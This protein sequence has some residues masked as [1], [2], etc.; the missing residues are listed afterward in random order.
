MTREELEKL[1]KNADKYSSATVRSTTQGGG[2]NQAQF[3]SLKENA[4]K[5]VSST[6]RYATQSELANYYKNGAPTLTDGIMKA[7]YGH[8]LKSQAY[9]SLSND[10][11]KMI[12]LNNQ[13]NAYKKAKDVFDKISY[14]ER[15]STSKKSD[16]WQKSKNL[17]DNL[18]N[19][20]RT[21]YQSIYGVDADFDKWLGSAVLQGV[22]QFNVGLANTGAMAGNLIP[23]AI[24][25]A[26]RYLKFGTDVGSTAQLR[27]A[28][29]LNDVKGST[30]YG[31]MMGGWVNQYEKAIGKPDEEM[32]G[33]LNS[34]EKLKHRASELSA[35]GNYNEA[36]I[37][38]NRAQEFYDRISK[39]YENYLK[40]NGTYWSIAEGD[41]LL[42]EYAQMVNDVY[43]REQENYEKQLEFQ[44]MTASGSGKGYEIAGQL[45]TSAVAALPYAGLSL[46]TGGASL[47]QFVPEGHTLVNAATLSGSGIGAQL[48]PQTTDII[49]KVSNILTSFGKDPQ[50]W[51]SFAQEAGNTY[52]EAIDA[53]ADA[54]VATLTATLVGLINGAIELGFGG[55]NAGIQDLPEKLLKGKGAGTR[56]AIQEWI[57][58]AIS[59]G[60]EEILQGVISNLAEKIAYNKDMK[61]IGEGGVIDPQALAQEG[62]MGGAVGALLGGGQ[63]MGVNIM[64]ESMQNRIDQAN[65]RLGQRYSEQADTIV[66]NARQ[67]GPET[68]SYQLASDILEKGSHTDAE[69]GELYRAYMGDTGYNQNL[70]T[71][72]IQAVQQRL[73][74]LGETSNT[75]ELAEIIAKEADGQK[76]TEAETQAIENSKYGQ[77]VVNELFNAY[78]GD[79]S[80]NWVRGLVTQDEMAAAKAAPELTQ[81][82]RAERI[83]SIEQ[84]RPER[85]E[86]D[87][88]DIDKLA[89]KYGEQANVFKEA[90]KSVEGTDLY[91]FDDAYHLVY[92]EAKAGLSEDTIRRDVKAS[93]LSP[94]A[95]KLAYNAGQS[96]IKMPKGSR[97]TGSA[98]VRLNGIDYKSLNNKQRASVRALQTIAQITG[99]RIE[100][101]DST[102][103]DGTLGEKQGWYSKG[104]IGIDINAGMLDKGDILNVAMLRTTSHELTH[105]IQDN[106]DTAY[107][108]LKDFVFS[109][110]QTYQFSDGKYRDA[111]TWI[112]SKMSQNKWEYEEGTAEFNKYYQQASDECVADACE[113]MLRDSTA[114]ETLA[115][116]N[117]SLAQRMLD[118]LK[119]LIADIKKAFSG[120]VETSLEARAML[121]SLD[122]L[123]KKWDAAL[124]G[125]VQNTKEY[126][127]DGVTMTNEEAFMDS[128]EAVQNQIRPPYTDKT[129]AFYEFADNLNSEARETFDLFYGFYQRSRLT[130]T[131]NAQ[132]KP[133]KGINISAP[134]L[135]VQQWNDK[136]KADKKWAECARGLAEF[137]PEKVRTAMRMN[138]DG[139]LK[140]NPLE[141]RFKMQISLAQRLVDALPLEKIDINYKL[142]NKTIKLS[143]GKA[144]QS[145][146][147][148][149]YRRAVI[150]E[151]RKLYAEGKLKKVSIGAMS[152]DRWGSLGFLA[153]NGKTG[154]SGDLTT[155]CPQMMFNEGCFYCYRRAA[156]ETG[157]NNKLVAQRV[158]YTGEILRIKDSDVKALNENGG[159]RIQSFGDWMPQFSAQLADILYDAELRGLQVKIITKEPSMIEYIARLENQGIGKSLYFNLSSDYAIEKGPAAPVNQGAES[160]A[161]V[162]WERPFMRTEDGTFWWKRAMTVEEAQK[163]R[164]KYPWVN[165][166][167][168]ATDIAEFIRG[169]RDP[170]VDVVTGYHGH[171]RTW[172]RIDSTTGEHKVQVEP[173]GDAGMPRF[174]F[175]PETKSWGIEYAGKTKVH[176]ALAQ[177]I[178]DNGLQMEYYTKTCCITGRCATCNGKCGALAR[179]FSVKNATNRDAESVAYWQD[180]MTKAEMDLD[181]DIDDVQNSLRVTPEQN[182]R[183][184]E[185]AKDPKK[186]EAELRKMVEQAARSA[187]YDVKAYHGTH[188]FG[189]TKFNRQGWSTYLTSK[190]SVAESFSGGIG[191]RGITQRLDGSM[192]EKELI[193]YA[194]NS[195]F[196]ENLQLAT[197]EQIDRAYERFNDY[198]KQGID[199]ARKNG[200]NI[201]YWEDDNLNSGIASLSEIRKLVAEKINQ[202]ANGGIYAMYAR[203]GKALTVNGNGNWYYEIPVTGDISKEIGSNK[204]STD[205]ILRYADEHGYDSVVYKN[206]RESGDSGN[207]GI[208]TVYAVVNP[209]VN[210]KSA[211][212]VTYDDS[213]N[214]IPLSER[215]NEEDE[216]IRYSRRPAQVKRD[217]GEKL[218]ESE[219]Y[220]LYSAHKLNLRGGQNLDEQIENI[221]T[222]GF[223]NTGGFTGNLMPTNL[224]YTQDENGNTKPANVSV[225]RYA[226][227]EGD[228]ILLVPK[229]GVNTKSD[230]VALG[231]KPSFDYEIV[232]ADYDYQPYYEMYSKAYDADVQYSQ[233]WT[234]NDGLLQLD[235][236]QA[237]WGININTDERDFISEILNSN[238]DV[239][240]TIETRANRNV[241]K[242]LLGQRVGL[243]ETHTGRPARLV[244]YATIS[245]IDRYDTREEF[246]A[247]ADKHR[248]TGGTYDYQE[249]VKKYGYTLTNVERVEPKEILSK[250]ISKR[251]LN[252]DTQYQLRE[253]IST[254]EAL[255][256]ALM[257]ITE[258][259]DERTRLVKYID[260][261]EKVDTAQA[262]VNELGKQ[263]HDI[264]FTKG[265]DRSN[266]A[267]LRAEK[268]KLE[269]DIERYDKMLIGL[270]STKPLKD[271]RDRALARANAELRN[272]QREDERAKKELVKNYTVAF[273]SLARSDAR[274]LA[275][276]A[277]ELAR[278]TSRVESFKRAANRRETT[279]IKNTIKKTVDEWRTQLEDK[280]KG[281]HIPRQLVIAVADMV[282]VL[283]TT[284]NTVSGL[285]K[286]TELQAL[287]SQLKND[288]D[289]K[290]AYDTSVAGMFDSLVEVIDETPLSEM[291]Y[292]QLSKVYDIVKA[293]K[294]TIAEARQ[295]KSKEYK[296]NIFDT[297]KAIINEMIEASPSFKSK[298]LEAIHIWQLDPESFFVGELAGFKKDA[299][300][301]Q[302]ARSFTEGTKRATMVEMAHQNHF[303][304]FITSRDIRRLTNW[305]KTIDVGLVDMKTG[306]KVMMPR[307]AALGMYMHTL[308]EDNQLAL[309]YG[310]LHVPGNWKTYYTG[311]AAESY[312]GEPIRV[313][314]EGNAEAINNI[315]E[316][317]KKIDEL[318]D[319]DDL[320]REEK[321]KLKEKYQNQQ[322]EYEQ[323][324]LGEIQAVRDRIYSQMTETEKKYVEAIQQWF[325]GPAKNFAN[326]VT[327]ELWDVK[328]AQVKNYWPM[329]RDKAFIQSGDIGASV[330]DVNLS[331]AGWLKQR[332]RSS[333]PIYLTDITYEL[334]Q[335]M[336]NLARFYGYAIAQRDFNKI[337]NVQLGSQNTSVKEQVNRFGTGPRKIGVSAETYIDNY[338][339]DITG[340]RVTAG[341]S[342]ISLIR[343]THPRATLTGSIR[344]WFSQLASLPTAAAE[345]GWD[346]AAKG[347]AKGFASAFSPKF[348]EELARKSP[349][350]WQRY[351][352]QGGMRELAEMKQGNTAIDRGWNAVTNLPVFSAIANGTQIFDCYAT[353]NEYFMAEEWVKK[354]RPGLKGEEFETAVMEKYDAIIHHTQPN[355]TPTERSD[356]LRDKREGYKFLTMYKTQAN[357]NYNMLANALGKY[358]KYKSDFKNKKNGVTAADVKDATRGLANTVSAVLIGETLLF[359]LGRAL[360]NMILGH[361]RDYRDDDDEIT[362]AAIAAS[363]GKE[364]VNSIAGIFAFGGQLSDA[365]FF[366]FSKDHT[367]RGIE[368]SGLKTLSEGAEYTVKLIKAVADGDV[369]WAD[370]ERA[371]KSDSAMLGLPYNN[372]KTIYT[373]AVGWAKDISNHEFGTYEAFVTRSKKTNYT[374][375]LKAL[376][377]GDAEKAENIRAELRENDPD[378]EDSEINSGVRSVI[379]DIWKDGDLTSDAA[380]KLMVDYTDMDADD[381]YWAVQKWYNTSLDKE[382]GDTKYY[383]LNMA[384]AN[385]GDAGDAIS[386]LLEH[387]TKADD[388]A[389]HIRKDIIKAAYDKGEITDKEATA[390][391]VKY[392]QHKVAGR[393]VAYSADEA[394]DL[395][396][397]W[398]KTKALDWDYDDRVALLQSG[399]I[400]KA[401]I[402]K[403]YM[404]IEDKSSEEADEWIAKN[405]LGWSYQ[406][407]AYLYGEGEITKSELKKALMSVDGMSSE[408]AD[409]TIETY[410]W[411]NAGY[412]V[413]PN[414][415][416]AII[417]T[418]Y[419]TVQK[420]GIS[421]A[422]WYDYYKW[423]SKARADKDADGN[424]INGTK[425]AK[426]FDYIGKLNIT[427]DQKMVLA[428]TYTDNE[429]SIAKYKTW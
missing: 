343:R 352:G 96:D 418:Y 267:T 264:M 194:S 400:S 330:E 24:N 1:K 161:Q 273:N 214:V 86:E 123:Q 271:L 9:M 72:T 231:Y 33:W 246:E 92:Q 71:N 286:F 180:H 7:R 282:S 76:I 98:G 208:S 59:E 218:T 111:D 39:K 260:G 155:L 351:K 309:I 82:Q 285:K 167:I 372:L 186:N 88:K 50:Y 297:G 63:I 134:Y 52:K 74:E 310:T 44:K 399:E 305:K 353:A 393:L 51:L 18:K 293:M 202:S 197:Q 38:N 193:K 6:A 16:S 90:A 235:N 413:E 149:A 245:Q 338:I 238:E 112:R 306:K 370:V 37:Y 376:E 304:N 10:D 148:E 170:H 404:D 409:Q 110:L 345:V 294:K 118:W 364:A 361:V 137:L 334:D 295:T 385:D 209:N 291:N 220:S 239:R 143:D 388:V 298:R 46:M 151:T 200:E 41:D 121:D 70:H 319:N 25:E 84:N 268:N 261:I 57:E 290:D 101:F 243:V 65:A 21:Q 251:L 219:F 152:K 105:F 397:T 175:N 119:Q 255:A 178:E 367:Y 335:S 27:T 390:K 5:Y 210:L 398:S 127:A 225:S 339:K 182:A 289:Y 230:S 124:V 278:M 403:A 222:E 233:R 236:A 296:Q 325:D 307:G 391:L 331:N 350:Y 153:A 199:N 75:R 280:S 270:Q 49:G 166:R 217:A 253:Q 407:K 142:G 252:E 405:S 47:A 104:A 107:K 212:P 402:K 342:I 173:L 172:D 301:G 108:E 144:V 159:L 395:V 312:G 42:S 26:T 425:M 333:A 302:I 157:V 69:I 201:Y 314:T 394:K 109:A 185:L 30:L 284:A 196:M 387:G 244:G 106:N 164:E 12:Q 181:E 81:E 189:K 97:F 287:Y 130:N 195:T 100:L 341:D 58:S 2:I 366:I 45:V 48:A 250:G 94:A 326:E 62:Y 85:T 406:D 115:K 162:N 226:P 328:K 19:E 346:S 64:N 380:V 165:T 190:P 183:Y 241:F 54:N 187:G 283:D 20:L 300:W 411:S 35:K 423:Q 321:Q 163:F 359:V 272:T 28:E 73:T 78:R 384:I 95:F 232:T 15:N 329:H 117:Q 43:A 34:Y 401:E 348:K 138:E 249:G 355:Y 373:G 213:G 365:L 421:K 89:Q 203:L 337:Y 136:L 67:M 93:L 322:M 258:N 158:W 68:R 414:Q 340:G 192:S 369:D 23:S 426:V 139:T 392:G 257:N 169:L 36:D 171:I 234:A 428:R 11:K 79:Y 396:T 53:G 317:G 150:D 13:V 221:R 281:K 315:K 324:A 223:K 4:D 344:V 332:V 207:A 371:I 276:T 274:Q 269:K 113:M 99:L 381:A 215:F 116:E 174:S 228:T 311:N 145:V 379:K 87:Y 160:L 375:L 316:L 262:R 389:T 347:F 429:K 122:E 408:Q 360:A 327:M 318:K 103:A 275:I 368:D 386:E 147:G 374:R 184:M 55:D 204:A 263:I 417:G 83:E 146:G 8:V 168:V 410:E 32:R 31:T 354:H 129:K 254:R 356:L 383:R 237:K 323:Q 156:M 177:A 308:G 420:A 382:E 349:T 422:I 248:I 114:F 102:Q 205:Q 247:D 3:D 362:A 378:I 259:E 120:V 416:N 61:W 419:D 29:E 91:Y 22:N 140:P 77:R 427:N 256:V 227:R 292:E 377:D 224:S 240:K 141:E 424:S 229:S 206:I 303:A 198:G 288:K 125:A 154:A 14:S 211:D 357:K 216:D 358:R 80:S 299:V 415:Y 191:V 277:K 132:G 336:R 313:R 17:V 56:R 188:N 242:S 363:I 66:Q 279:A 133:V 135:T 40:S 266:L 412:E 320:T 176:Q 179:S 265:S 126:N 60:K 128:A 131:T